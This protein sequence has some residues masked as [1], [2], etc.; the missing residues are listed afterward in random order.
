L[1]EDI[2]KIILQISEKKLEIM[3]LKSV[4]NRKKKRIEKL[5]EAL[6]HKRVNSCIDLC[7]SDETS[8]DG[9]GSTC[10]SLDGVSFASK[11]S[12]EKSK[13]SNKLKDKVI[14]TSSGKETKSSQLTKYNLYPNEEGEA[15]RSISR[16]RSL[17]ALEQAAL[18]AKTTPR[19]NSIIGGLDKWEAE[20]AEIDKLETKPVRRTVSFNSIDIL[21]FEMELGD[22]PSTSN[23]LPV[24]LGWE[25]QRA[26][27]FNLDA[28]ESAKPIPRDRTKMKIPADVRQRIVENQGVSRS[29]AKSAMAEVKKTKMRRRSSVDNMKW[30]KLS[31]KKEKIGRKLKSV[32]CLATSTPES[33]ELLKQL[34]QLD[35]AVEF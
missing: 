25:C 10:R 33:T 26:D 1:V 24:Q 17:V 27:T 28:Y 35:C 31:Y 5:R 14:E 4:R 22:N 13:S 3:F 15:K 8:L 6:N 11:V 20:L 7:L 32:A 12:L 30:D 29:E 9:I 34:E 19:R 23:G 2:T 16:R 18:V 21:E